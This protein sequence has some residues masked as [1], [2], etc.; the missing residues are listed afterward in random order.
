M[1]RLYQHRGATKNSALRE[2]DGEKYVIYDIREWE[3]VHSVAEWLEF[4]L[5]SQDTVCRTD[6]RSGRKYGRR[7]DTARGKAWAVPL[8]TYSTHTQE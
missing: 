4:V 2:I 8:A 6:T 3:R 5:D 7:I 1:L